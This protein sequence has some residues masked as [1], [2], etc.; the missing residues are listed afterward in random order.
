[1]FGGGRPLI[2]RSTLRF[3]FPANSSGGRSWRSSQN[4]CRQSRNAGRSRAASSTAGQNTIKNQSQSLW[5]NTIATWGLIPPAAAAVLGS[6]AYYFSQKQKKLDGETTDEFGSSLTAVPAW[7]DDIGSHPGALKVLTTEALLAQDH[8]FLED[9]H[10]FSAFV[11][12]GIV[13]D[14]EGWYLPEAQKFS[15]VVALGREVAGFPRVVHGGLTAAIFDEA[16][17]GL[18]FSLKKSKALKFW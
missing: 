14:I 8:P 3:P 12:R 10:M 13:R 5:N 18:L 4:K 2:L 6:L 1:M 15:A 11:A 17:G 9:D 7:A 16:F